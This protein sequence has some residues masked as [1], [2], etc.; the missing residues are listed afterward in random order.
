MQKKQQQQLNTNAENDAGKQQSQ[1][2]KK[3]TVNM[4]VCR[5]SADDFV[6]DLVTKQLTLWTSSEHDHIMIPNVKL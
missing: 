3:A 2:Q 1:M 5:H 4:F 6:V